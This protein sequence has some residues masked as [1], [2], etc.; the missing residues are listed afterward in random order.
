MIEPTM[1]LSKN[2]T[3]G[4]FLRSNTAERDENL[5][6]E[7][8]NPPDEIVDNL[9]YLVETALQPIRNNLGFPMRIKLCEFHCRLGLELA[10]ATPQSSPI[11]I[12]E[13]VRSAIN[14]LYLESHSISHRQRLYR[15]HW[16][17]SSR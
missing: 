8:F 14:K 17:S 2:F 6:R 1:P 5:K 9:K 13:Y 3:V 7:Q 10:I 11:G 15:L 12:K 16:H 4:E